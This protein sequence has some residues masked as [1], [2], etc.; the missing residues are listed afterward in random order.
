MRCITKNVTTPP[1][2]HIVCTDDRKRP[3]S[4][5]STA[6]SGFRCHQREDAENYVPQINARH[7]WI[8]V[9]LPTGHRAADH[10]N[11]RL[12]SRSPYTDFEKITTA[13]GVLSGA[14]DLVD[15]ERVHEFHL[16][17]PRLIRASADMDACCVENME[18]WD[19]VRPTPALMRID[20]VATTSGE[21]RQ[22]MC[23]IRSRRFIV[24]SY[25]GV[26]FFFFPFQALVRRDRPHTVHN[27][28]TS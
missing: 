25:T 17:S 13:C 15:P 23:L 8:R 27:H 26:S 11:S 10:A 7:L 3:L 1:L 18:R 28:S 4:T 6:S 20:P 14:D 2:L 9:R 22:S 5:R 16:R 21:W 19:G 24:S 12:P